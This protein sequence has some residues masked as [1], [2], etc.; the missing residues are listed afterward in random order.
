MED[1]KQIDENPCSKFPTVRIER[2]CVEGTWVQS[3]EPFIR[4]KELANE[5]IGC[6]YMIAGDTLNLNYTLIIK[7]NECV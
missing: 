1:V 2:I 5:D 4:C 3:G 6:V 7:E